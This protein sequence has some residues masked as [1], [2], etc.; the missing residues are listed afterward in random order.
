MSSHFPTI[1]VYDSSQAFFI[2]FM[3]FNVPFTPGTGRPCSIRCLNLIDGRDL[4]KNF[5]NPLCPAFLFTTFYYWLYFLSFKLYCSN[6]SQFTSAFMP[7]HLHS[8]PGFAEP[9]GFLIAGAPTLLANHSAPATHSQLLA[10]NGSAWHSI[11]STAAY[12]F[13]RH[14]RDKPSN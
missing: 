10:N 5:S 11:H 4:G 9:T 6:K 14:W 13:Q 1:Y 12:T 2:S 7:F 8:I 3:N